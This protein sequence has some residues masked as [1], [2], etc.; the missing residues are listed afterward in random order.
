MSRSD[1][2]SR[3]E[4]LTWQLSAFLNQIGAVHNSGNG[5]GE[6]EGEKTADH[7]DDA[8]EGRNRSGDDECEDPVNGTETDPE[9][10]ALLGGDVWE[11]ED[12]LANFDVDG[13]EAN[14]EV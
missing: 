4:A 13:L 5:V 11:V 3:I 10:P 9:P 8:V 14:V 12:F 6:V 2:C 1:S 7:T